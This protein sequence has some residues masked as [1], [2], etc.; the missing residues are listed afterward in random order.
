MKAGDRGRVKEGRNVMGVELGLFKPKRFGLVFQL[1]HEGSGVLS[2]YHGC[3]CSHRA[4][5]RAN[6]TMH[7]LMGRLE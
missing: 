5:V 2:E 7:K 1:M 4:V 3:Y 6:K